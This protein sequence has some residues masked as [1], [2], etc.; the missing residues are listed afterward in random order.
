MT[1]PERMQALLDPSRKPDRVPFIPFIFGFC[2]KNCGWEVADIYRDARKS[3]V[4]QL[5]AQEQYGYDG[6]TLYGYAAIG[7]WEFGGEIKM[8]KGEFDQA[9]HHRPPPRGDRR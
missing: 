8:P 9:P 2:P 6:G 3:F 4:S 7:A 1:S 5:R